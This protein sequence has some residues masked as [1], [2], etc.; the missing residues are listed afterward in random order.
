MTL[1]ID[2]LPASTD[3]ATPWPPLGAKGCCPKHAG[4]FR[5]PVPPP[6]M[7]LGVDG[8]VVTYPTAMNPALRGLGGCACDSAR[9]T[10]M[11]GLGAFPTGLI[12]EATAEARRW[13]TAAGITLPPT[14]TD[15][16]DA[17]WR[18]AATERELEVLRSKLRSMRSAGIPLD[19][20]DINAYKTAADAWYKAAQQTINPIL[21]LIARTNPSAAALLPRVSRLPGLDDPPR[22]LPFVPSEADMAKIRSGDMTGLS[23]VFNDMVANVRSRVL[24]GGVRGLGLFGIDDL[25]IGTLVLIV[26]GLLAIAAIAVSIAV[27]AYA[28]VQTVASYA[29]ARAAAD[30]A[31]RRRAFYERCLATGDTSASCARQAQDTIA[32]PPPPPD[33]SLFSIGAGAVLAAAGVAALGYYF[34]ATPGGRARAGL[35]GVRRRRR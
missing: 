33:S 28:L 27:P 34:L 24:G 25:T 29:A 14:P 4:L 15:V 13:A 32:M 5:D 23:G 21:S 2:L 18:V 35:S 12:D 1:A 31:D 30:A 3:H 7:L 16:L 19:A 6:S 17:I 10:A 22:P 11:S 9:R 26:V 20:S 8:M